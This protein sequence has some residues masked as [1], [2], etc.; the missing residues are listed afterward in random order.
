MTT[1]QHPGPPSLTRRGPAG[2]AHN[3]RPAVAPDGGIVTEP[4]LLLAGLALLG[5][6]ALA[7]AATSSLLPLLQ[8]GATGIGVDAGPDLWRWTV[9]PWTAAIAS[10]VYC[11]A[12]LAYGLIS[13]R[14]GA[15]PRAAALRLVVG[16][17]AVVHLGALLEGLWRLPEASRTF[18]LTL[19]SLL[20][21]ELALCAVLGWRS[22]AAL[23]RKPIRKKPSAAAVVGSLF[24]ASVL[25]AAV[26][27]V[28][29][30]ASTAG[31][32]AVPHSGHGG[33]HNSPS[34]PGNIQQLKDQGHHH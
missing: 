1:A 30:A 5:I 21:L 32:L 28:G 12:A 17:A 10:A 19:A 4:A 24:V 2:K 25:V 13:L 20:V 14:S 34:V 11:M 7:G 9:W 27:T 6:A 18:D 16:L 23:R 26:T 8:G 22:N 29:M 15:L 33:N 31:E 3:A